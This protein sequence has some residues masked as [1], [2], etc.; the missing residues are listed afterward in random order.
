MFADTKSQSM[1]RWNKSLDTY[2]DTWN[3]A[4]K[5]LEE[6]HG[7]HNHSPLTISM[8]TEVKKL[9]ENSQESVVTDGFRGESKCDFKLDTTNFTDRV[10]QDY[11][12]VSNPTKSKDK[13]ALNQYAIR[14]ELSSVVA[15]LRLYSMVEFEVPTLMY[16]LTIK[17]WLAINEN[18]V[19]VGEKWDDI[20]KSMNEVCNKINHLRAERKVTERLS[21]ILPIG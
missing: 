11:G 18:S 8:L 14:G 16:V 5:N 9:L 2:L 20:E 6:H 3:K 19:L 4:I 10:F 12:P 7:V 1:A 13:I 17:S 15:M 21:V